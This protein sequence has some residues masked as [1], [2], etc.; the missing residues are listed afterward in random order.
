MKARPDCQIS[1]MVSL[2]HT[3]FNSD[4]VGKVVQLGRRLPRK[5]EDLNSE[6]LAPMGKAG[7]SNTLG[8]QRREDPR[9]LDGQP[10]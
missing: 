4:T 9:D 3:N 1:W 5:H 6:T 8:K 2:H 7:N 10:I